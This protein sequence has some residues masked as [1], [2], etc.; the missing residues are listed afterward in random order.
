[1]SE[2]TSQPNPI[3]SLPVVIAGLLWLVLGGIG[4]FFAGPD[5]PWAAPLATGGIIGVAVTVAAALVRGALPAPRVNPAAPNKVLEE[6]TRLLTQIHEHTMLSDG[7]KRLIYRSKELQLLRNAIDE[8]IQQGDYDAAL[9]LCTTMAENFGFREEAERYR[10]HIN[11]IRRDRYDEQ[12]REA[13]HHFDD[14]LA[15][16]DWNAA[17]QEASRIRRLF[18]ES[19]VVGELDTRITAARDEQKQALTDRFLQAANHGEVESAM[20]LLRQLDRDLTKPEAERLQEVA[21]GVVTR[22][23]E[24][25]GVQF[26]ITVRD[27]NWAEAVRIGND[28]IAEFPKSKMADEV[29]SM[30]DVLQTRATQAAVA[31]GSQ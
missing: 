8:D 7:S 26:N 22:H 29:R 5:R 28:I 6:H 4:L 21:H 27:K 19:A 30:L 3:L 23:R 25:L 12:V 17:H 14:A 2:S 11:T 31:A 20:E 1:M 9:I 10:E 13:M 15:H 18:P 16:R 24:N